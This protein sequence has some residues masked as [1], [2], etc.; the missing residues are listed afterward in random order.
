MTAVKQTTVFFVVKLV[1]VVL[2]VADVVVYVV[3]IVVSKHYNLKMI[4]VGKG[5]HKTTNVKKHRDLRLSR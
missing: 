1:V 4:I 3:V 2:L 5:S